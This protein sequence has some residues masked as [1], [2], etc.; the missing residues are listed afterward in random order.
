MVIKMTKRFG[1]N[2][3]RRLRA[4]E[5]ECETLASKLRNEV[6]ANEPYRELVRQV[7]GTLGDHY[8][9]LA[10]E[11]VPVH[12]ADEIGFFNFA[13][14]GSRH[15]PISSVDAMELTNH[16][17]AVACAW[18]DFRMDRVSGQIYARLSSD[19]GD[20]GFCLSREAANGRSRHLI[21][22]EMAKDIADHFLKQLLWENGGGRRI[23]D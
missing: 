19:R 15:R 10:G 2:Q 8:A 11:S 22:R 20:M 1:R 23:I 18:V 16:L 9:A 4:A 13:L 6:A 14:N 12:V 7:R 3:R 17:K 5:A 21:A